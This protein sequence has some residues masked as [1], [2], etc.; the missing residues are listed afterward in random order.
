MV[1]GE[2]AVAL[3]LSRQSSVFGFILHVVM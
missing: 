1:Y 3:H 2:N